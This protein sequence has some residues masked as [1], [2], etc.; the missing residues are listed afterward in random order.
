MNKENHDTMLLEKLLEKYRFTR[1]VP[2]DV[3]DTILSSKKKNLVRILKTT[4]AFS[5]AYGLFLSVYFALKKMG[6]G[7]PVMKFVISGVSVAAVAYG[8]YYMITAGP[9]ADRAAPPPVKNLSLEE[10]RSQYKW[11]DRITL[12][13]GKVVR[14]AIMSRGETYRVLTTEGIMMIPRNRIKMVTPL[15]MSGEDREAAPRGSVK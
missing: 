11:V 13:N 1:P 10:I 7:I 5:A 8:G 14:G 15:K 4:G 3:Q 9:R 12:Y 2:P 6:I